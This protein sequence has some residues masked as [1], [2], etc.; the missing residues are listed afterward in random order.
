[1]FAVAI[2]LLVFDGLT[3]TWLCVRSHRLARRRRE[4]AARATV[5]P[6]EATLAQRLNEDFARRQA[7]LLEQ[8][9]THPAYDAQRGNASETVRRAVAG[10]GYEIRRAAELLAATPELVYD[11]ATWER[12]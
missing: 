1:V 8:R 10:S 2:C 12:W 6:H 11:A 7:L 5:V 4:R 3:T 9:S